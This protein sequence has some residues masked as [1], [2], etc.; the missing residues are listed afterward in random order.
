M[1]PEL[2]IVGGRE[3]GAPGGPARGG[4][5]AATPAAKNAAPSDAAAA[6]G[7]YDRA[8]QEMLRNPDDFDASFRF[9]Q[10]AAEL[11]HYE[12]AISALERLLLLNPDMPEIKYELGVLYYLIDSYA[13]ARTYL[14]E[15]RDAPSAS[16]EIKK[17]AIAFLD[18][19]DRH[20]AGK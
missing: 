8:F 2:D 17:R 19:L 18:E 4:D 15:A 16:D 9:A 3:V 13:V 7:D 14:T 1:L 20:L 12:P 11:G 10:L 5:A 6:Q